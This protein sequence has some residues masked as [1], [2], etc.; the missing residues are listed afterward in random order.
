MPDLSEGPSRDSNR[1]LTPD[2]LDP[3]VS[4][5][6]TIPSQTWRSSE[7]ASS[8]HVVTCKDTVANG[9][10]ACP[11]GESECAASRSRFHGKV[12]DMYTIQCPANC[13]ADE[14]PVYG[15]SSGD[16]DAGTCD[17]AKEGTKFLDHS[18]ICRCT[19]PTSVGPFLP[20]R[21]VCTVVNGDA[22]S[23]LRSLIDPKR[24]SHAM[25]EYGKH[26]YSLSPPRSRLPGL[27]S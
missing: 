3:K 18:S 9:N 13:A 2:F 19:Y 22:V 23:Q 15:P 27:E 7:Q 20:A 12:G 26:V 16:D 5:P 21:K 11:P 25:P 4:C 1:D 10:A 6:V 17:P 8:V 14:T 24:T